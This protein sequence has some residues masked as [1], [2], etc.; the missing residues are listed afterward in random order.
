[1]RTVTPRIVRVSNTGDDSN[2]GYTWEYPK[3]TVQ[4]AIDAYAS[5]PVEIW[6]AAGV[7][8]E[9]ITLRR[10]AHLYGGFAG[11]ESDR[12]ERN[13]QDNE[14]ALMG[15]ARGS[16]VKAVDIGYRTSTL[17]GFTVRNGIHLGSI[18]QL[19][20]AGIANNTITG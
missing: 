2:S 16:V 5:A 10:Y 1:M 20:G 17:D 14:T 18:L 8:I 6:V 4:A 12:L 11:T 9:Q 19:C 13:W 15:D 3:R 7:Y